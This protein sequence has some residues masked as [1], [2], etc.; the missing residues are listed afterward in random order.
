MAFR[1][2]F[3]DKDGTLVEDVPYNIDPGLIRLA[4]G[5]AEALPALHAAGYR[6]VVV[7]NQSGVARGYFPEQALAEYD[8]NDFERAALIDGERD[9]LIS[10][11]LDERI[12]AWVP[13]KRGRSH[14]TRR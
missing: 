11:G 6:L 4:P 12:T 1:A 5:A 14:S 9:G 8:L 3:L 10:V 13:W 7:S 2:V